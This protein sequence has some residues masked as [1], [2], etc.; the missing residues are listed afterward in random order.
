MIYELNLNTR[1]FEVRPH[2]A[3]RSVWGFWILYGAG[4]WIQDFSMSLL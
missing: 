2:W 4:R 1:Y 3:W